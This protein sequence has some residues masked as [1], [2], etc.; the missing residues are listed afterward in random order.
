MYRRVTCCTIAL[1]LVL[2]LA[3]CSDKPATPTVKGPVDP[4][5]SGPVKAGGGGAG[6]KA[7]GND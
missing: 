3:G 4:N 2:S 5:A 1:A 6:P 7:K